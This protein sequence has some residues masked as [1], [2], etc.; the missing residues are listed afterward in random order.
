MNNFRRM[1]IADISEQLQD[2]MS[3]LESLQDE[4]QE[5]FD[6]M[7]ENLQYSARGKRTE[8]RIYQINDAVT[9]VEE[10]IYALSL[11]IKH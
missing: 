3:E 6:S 10:A 9:A 11:A 5:Y 7:P 2:F 4:E 8:N 1:R